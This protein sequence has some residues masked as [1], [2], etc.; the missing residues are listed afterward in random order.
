MHI[1]KKFRT[2]VTLLAM[3]LL[4]TLFTACPD[5]SPN[6]YNKSQTQNNTGGGETDGGGTSGGDNSD[7]AASFKGSGSQNDPFILSDA[8][9][10]RKLAQDV[11]NGKTY[12]NFYFK[13]TNDIVIN[14]NV[15]SS[16]GNLSSNTSGF[17]QWTPIGNSEKQ[18]FCGTLDGNGHTIYGIYIDEENNNHKGLFGY[19]SGTVQNLTIKDSYISGPAYCGAIAGE[20]V[21]YL[22]KPLILNCVNYA[23]V[24]GSIGVGGIV[25]ANN[26]KECII[27]KCVN[28][29]TIGYNMYNGGIIGYVQ[30]GKVMNS[31]NYGSINDGTSGG[32][33]GGI[34]G[35]GDSKVNGP[36]FY[37]CVNFGLVN[38][39]TPGGWG[40]VDEVKEIN[41]CVNYGEIKVPKS[42]G[43]GIGGE[44]YS[45]EYV[46]NT[47][48]LNI[49][50]STGF[51]NSVS[52]TKCKAMTGL[53]MQQKSFLDELNKNAKALGSEYVQWKFGSD[54]F[55]TLDL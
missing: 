26:A 38:S 53:E 36:V 20:T 11:N 24:L 4:H 41:N 21:L 43:Y 14:K 27:N 8:S 48:Y 25:G 37:N 44:Y 29:G 23:Q 1:M 13:M 55:P 31:I 16:N 46:N 3:C 19:L 6:E 52:S 10:L 30:C 51:R 15:L 22:S 40:I 32:L 7:V 47:Y 18:S 35:H 12:Q 39:T 50:A 9:E 2:L 34:A 28:Y 42:L 33:I 49:S 17:E 45:K 54:G 5:D